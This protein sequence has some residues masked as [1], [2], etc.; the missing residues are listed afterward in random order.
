MRMPANEATTDFGGLARAG[1]RGT[2]PC[3]GRPVG[4]N[5]RATYRSLSRCR[6]AQAVAAQASR[7]RRARRRSTDPLN[8]ELGLRGRLRSVGRDGVH[9]QWV[10]THADDHRRLFHLLQPVKRSGLR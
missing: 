10:R 2:Q 9:E 1:I 3:R 7:V 6:G 4:R 5:D 8:L